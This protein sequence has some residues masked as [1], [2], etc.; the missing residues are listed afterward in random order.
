[1]TRPIDSVLARLEPF[2][3]REQGRERWRA[4]CPAH[5]G[6]SANTLSVGVGDGDC[7][8]LRCWAGC[9]VDAVTQALGLDVG[10][11]FPRR[12]AH[13]PEMQRRRLL[14]AAQALEL[15]ESVATLVVVVASDMATGKAPDEATRKALLRSAARIIYMR[16]EV[17]A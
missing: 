5:G 7:V 14:S 3:V 11:L 8:L 2:G 4:R 6:K 9:D 12:D 1:V 13:A 10:D 17:N 15:L 16:H